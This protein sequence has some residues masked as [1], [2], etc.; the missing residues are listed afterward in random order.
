[1][2]SARRVSST[3][4]WKSCYDAT[5]SG[6]SWSR[7]GLRS[8]GRRLKGW[9]WRRLGS[10]RVRSIYLWLR[11]CSSRLSGRGISWRISVS[12]IRYLFLLIMWF[13]CRRRSSCSWQ[14]GRIRQ[15]RRRNRF[16]KCCST[17]PPL[18]RSGLDKARHELPTKR[19]SSEQTLKT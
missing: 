11:I 7:R 17:L 5:I 12:G 4:S 1:M 10:W 14:G 9:A 16:W 6:V 3:W 15:V 18:M 2:N 8:S 19:C 13:R